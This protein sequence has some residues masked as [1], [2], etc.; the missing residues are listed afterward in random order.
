MTALPSSELAV[1]VAANPAATLVR[2]LF[3]RHAVRDGATS[4]ASRRPASALPVR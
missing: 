2:F 4:A 3:L 1:L